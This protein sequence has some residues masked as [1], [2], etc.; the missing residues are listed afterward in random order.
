MKYLEF[1]FFNSKGAKH[2]HY[3]HRHCKSKYLSISNS[4]CSCCC[5]Y[6]S[7]CCCC[8]AAVVWTQS[9]VPF[10]IYWGASNW[11]CK[12]SNNIS[13]MYTKRLSLLFIALLC[14]HT[15]R[16]DWTIYRG[17]SILAVVWD[18]LH[19][20]PLPP[21]S[22]TGDTNEDW[23]RDNLLTGKGGGGRAWSRIIQSLVVYKSANPLC[24]VYRVRVAPQT[25]QKTVWER[26]YF[27]AFPNKR[28]ILV[29][30]YPSYRFT[31]T[32]K[33]NHIAKDS[34]CTVV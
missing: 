27:C 13:F 22:W 8:C 32:V 31:F 15:D 25:K 30:L 18:R 21:V 9:P 20:H 26:D 12:Y 11:K 5:C 7:S 33:N 3:A 23:K 1:S 16:E 34:A 2:L 6:R 29:V 14:G 17:P 28:F 19:A 10:C 4:H 24:T